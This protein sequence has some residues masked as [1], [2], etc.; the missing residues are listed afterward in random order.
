MFGWFCVTVGVALGSALLPLISVEVFVLGLVTENPRVHWAM[1]GA[2]VAIGQVAGKLLYY[3][4]ARGSIRLPSFLHNQAH[5]ERPMLRRSSP[6][7]RQPR[8]KRFATGESDADRI[9]LLSVGS[10]TP[11][12]E[13]WR[14]RTKGLRAKLDGL[15][16]RCHRHPG[17]MA[18]TYTVSA[19]VGL[20]PYMAMTVLAGFARMRMSL[21]IGAGLAGRF[22]RYS[23]LAAS[24][25]LFAGWMH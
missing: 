10:V 12:R 25:A 19:L 6:I 18:V 7:R 21:F 13:A 24:P 5:R 22:A 3:L 8:R 2:A 4:A 1:I 23:V 20:P 16:E 15:R 9:R 11:R 17:W 14:A